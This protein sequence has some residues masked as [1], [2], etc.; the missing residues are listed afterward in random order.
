MLLNLIPTAQVLYELPLALGEGSEMRECALAN[1]RARLQ[2]FNDH[3]DPAVVL[4]PE[5][6]TEV[7]ALLE[8][9]SLA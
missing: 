7:A 1:V 2:G 3:E 4:D 9:G 5:A 8:V 6:L